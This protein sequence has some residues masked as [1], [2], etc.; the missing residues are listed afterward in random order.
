MILVVGESDQVVDDLL[1]CGEDVRAVTR[2]PETASAL[3]GKGVEV[4]EGDLEEPASL[5]RAFVRVERMYL[6]PLPSGAASNALA[7]H[8]QS[9]GYHAVTLAAL[10]DDVIHQLQQ[11]SLRWTVLEDASLAATALTEAGWEYSDRRQLPM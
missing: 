3:R 11:S 1:A 10:G 8:E 6:G 5:A 9:G 7:L 4:F 2:S